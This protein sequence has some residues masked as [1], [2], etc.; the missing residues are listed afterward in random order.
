MRLRRN[1]GRPDL[2][3]VKIAQAHD[4]A[5]EP[6]LHGCERGEQRLLLLFCR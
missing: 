3:H 1:Q 6:G 4:P 5:V 2:I